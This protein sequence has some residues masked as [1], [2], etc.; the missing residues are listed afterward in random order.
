MEIQENKPTSTKAQFPLPGRTKVP[1][2]L[3]SCA[4]D[5]RAGVPYRGRGT[6]GMRDSICGSGALPSPGSRLQWGKRRASRQPTNVSICGNCCSAHLKLLSPPEA[7]RPLT[8]QACFPLQCNLECSVS[9][10][11]TRGQQFQVLQPPPCIG[12]AQ[13]QKPLQLPPACV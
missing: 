10:N 9:E 11:R 1:V 7:V 5:T 2:S 8:L 4:H 3:R 6:V 13:E 12:K